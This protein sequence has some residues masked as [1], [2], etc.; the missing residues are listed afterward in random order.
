MKQLTVRWVTEELH[1]YTFD[2]DDDFDPDDDLDDEFL[3]E[4]EGAQTYEATTERD[5]ESW[6]WA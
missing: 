5:V 3:A 4:E 1:V 6:S 2:V